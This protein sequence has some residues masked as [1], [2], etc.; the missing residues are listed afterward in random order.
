MNITKGSIVKT[1]WGNAEVLRVWKD[2]CDLVL[3][4]NPT[5]RFSE[6]IINLKL[7]DGYGNIINER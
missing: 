5:T 7:C 1:K 2:Y 3:C 6:L 4:V